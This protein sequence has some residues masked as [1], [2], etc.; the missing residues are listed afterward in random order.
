MSQ[1]GKRLVY[2]NA[3]NAVA[4]AGLNAGKAVLSQSFLRFEANLATTQSS[5]VFDTLVNENT[6]PAFVT[7]QKLNLQDAFV[8]GEVG[9]YLAVPTTS[10]TTETR[11]KLYSYPSPTVFTG[12]GVED[13][14]NTVYNGNLNITIS[15]RTILPYWDVMRH[16]FIPQT[17]LTAAV[18]SPK[19]QFEATHQGLYTMEPNVVLVGS[20]KNIVKIDLPGAPAAVLANSRIVMICRGILMQNVTP[21]N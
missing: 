19:D 20:K 13:A 15:Q 18:N 3:K 2:Q 21:V 9:I 17:Q 4:R 8:I 16:L 11:V 12:A 14:M 1:M 7:Q 5:Y 6:N 10:A